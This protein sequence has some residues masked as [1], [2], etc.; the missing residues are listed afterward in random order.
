VKRTITRLGEASASRQAASNRPRASRLRKPDQVAKVCVEVDFH[1]L[2]LFA[3]VCRLG[4]A[5]CCLLAFTCWD[6][7]RPAGGKTCLG[8][9]T[10]DFYRRTDIT[11]EVEFARS[12]KVLVD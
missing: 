5:R 4:V 7:T 12:V 11:V 1:R 9:A 2:T 10:G 3:G 8:E 6:P